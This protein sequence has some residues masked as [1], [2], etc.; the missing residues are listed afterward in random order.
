MI[1]FFLSAPQ[2]IQSTIGH[3]CDLMTERTQVSTL[4]YPIPSFSI[5]LS[6]STLPYPNLSYSTHYLYLPFLLYCILP[7]FILC[8]IF[9]YT[10]IFCLLP[11]SFQFHTLPHLF[12][13]FFFRYSLID[14]ILSNHNLV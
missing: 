2:F 1:F 3:Y 8:H 11:Y 5:L 10:T 9:L 7:N 13:S 12:F 14:C 6:P 4:S